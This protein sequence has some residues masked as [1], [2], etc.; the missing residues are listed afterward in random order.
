LSL[1]DGLF[2]ECMLACSDE[3]SCAADESS[4]VQRASRRLQSLPQF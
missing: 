3:C 4:V 1:E 2:P